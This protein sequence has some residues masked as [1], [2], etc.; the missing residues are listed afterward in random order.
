[1]LWPQGAS[2]RKHL[3]KFL[4]WGVCMARIRVIWGVFSTSMLVGLVCLWSED[5]TP[6]LSHLR[7]PSPREGYIHTARA[8]VGIIHPGISFNLNVFFL[9]NS[10]KFCTY[11][12]LKQ[13]NN[14]NKS[15]KTQWK[16]KGRRFSRHLSKVD[17]QM[18]NKHM[19]R[20]SALLIT[21]EMQNKTTTRNHYTLLRMA[22]IKKIYK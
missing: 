16:K 18:A 4:A 1:M 21:R 19:K 9:I 22:V 14:N 13:L 17:R 10:F 8:P 11:E 5:R 15:R 2:P 12:Q 6:Q 3:V 20:C 7:C